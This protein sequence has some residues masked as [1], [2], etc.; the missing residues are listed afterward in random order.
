MPWQHWLAFLGGAC[1]ASA[2]GKKS[3]HRCWAQRRALLNK[4][5]ARIPGGK[6]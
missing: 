1:Q 2:M 6:L 4:V 3:W 5:V